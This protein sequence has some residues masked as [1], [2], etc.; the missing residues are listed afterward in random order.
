MPVYKEIINMPLVRIFSRS[1]SILLI[2]FLVS[3]SFAEKVPQYMIDLENLPREKRE[4]F[5]K[6]LSEAKR[7]FSQQ[8]II[9]A[10]DTIGEAETMIP[11]FPSLMS[12]KGA[13]YVELRD[14]DTAKKIFKRCSEIGPGNHRVLFNLGEVSFVQARWKESQGYFQKVLQLLNDKPEDPI[15]LLSEFKNYI[16]NNKLGNNDAAR[17]IEDKY[18]Y[19][20]DSPIYYYINAVKEFE[21]GNKVESQSYLQRAKTVYTNLG[22]LDPWQDCLIESGYIKSFYGGGDRDETGGPSLKVK[23][24]KE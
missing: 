6:H 4:V 17:I 10:L 16:A 15:Y 14:F 22:I 11:E 8:R 19:T 5:Y 21:A 20:F 24:V 1:L 12:I 18:D 3:F 13:C 23:P 7:L 2:S 9:E